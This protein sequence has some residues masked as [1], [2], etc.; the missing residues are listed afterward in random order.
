MHTKKYLH[1]FEDIF[2]N[3]IRPL[4]C[5]NRYLMQGPISPIRTLNCLVTHFSVFINDL[6]F[7]PFKSLE[8]K[9]HTSVPPL[10]PGSST[11]NR[12]RS[13]ELGWYLEEFQEF[14][15]SLGFNLW[16]K[17]LVSWKVS[18]SDF[19]QMFCILFSIRFMFFLFVLGA[20]GFLKLCLSY[21][22]WDFCNQFPKQVYVRVVCVCS[23]PTSPVARARDSWRDCDI[24]WTKHGLYLHTSKHP[25]PMCYC[26]LHMVL[27]ICVHLHAVDDALVWDF[28]HCLSTKRQLHFAYCFLGVHIW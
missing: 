5:C 9:I 1:L 22:K 26:G 16:S 17:T 15:T 28:W 24:H 11:K 27:L 8:P 3:H 13:T 14:P 2:C 23:Q 21:V 10:R 6:C 19:F 25:R 7:N 18:T 12:C 4:N 20:F